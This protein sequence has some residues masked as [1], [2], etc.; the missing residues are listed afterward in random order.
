MIVPITHM[1]MRFIVRR[2]L[3]LSLEKSGKDALLTS[4]EFVE[5]LFETPCSNSVYKWESM[6]RG[7]KKYFKIIENK[8]VGASECFRIVANTWLR[9]LYAMWKRNPPNDPAIFLVSKARS[10]V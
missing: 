3:L 5:K 4:E 7:V 10:A 1:P 2:K 8:G 6:R 9:I